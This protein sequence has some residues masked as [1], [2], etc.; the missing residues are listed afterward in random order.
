M[1]TRIR[2]KNLLE[3]YTDISRF[4]LPQCPQAAVL[5]AAE[6]DG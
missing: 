1:A 3:A 6:S 5:V 2:L 4:P